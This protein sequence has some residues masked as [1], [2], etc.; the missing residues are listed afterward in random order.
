MR[1][2]DWMDSSLKLVSKHGVDIL[3]IDSLCKKLKVTKG[4]FYHHFK[5]H[6]IFIEEILEYW[7]KTFTMDI[8]EKSKQ[9]E[10]NPLKQMELL[11]NTIYSKDLNIEIEFRA[12]GLRNELVLPYMEKIDKE[13]ILILRNI[14]DK[15]NPNL[16]EKINEEMTLLIYCKFLGTLFIQPRLSSTRN[17]ELD[18][19]LLNLVLSSK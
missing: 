8:I 19:F 2:E 17:K 15:L 6:K 1:K 12:W 11:N 7:Y 3:K 13:R 10:N 4:S 16:D 9:F 5:S 18:D 14:Q